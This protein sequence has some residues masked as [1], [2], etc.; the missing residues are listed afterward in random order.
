MIFTGAA[1]AF[2]DP[3]PLELDDEVALGPDAAVPLEAVEAVDPVDA[4]LDEPPHAAPIRTT[5]DRIDS[6]HRDLDLTTLSP[7]TFCNHFGQTQRPS[8]V[9]L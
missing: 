5:P 3:V 7:P 8:E 2:N 4:L 9:R 1:E 6:D